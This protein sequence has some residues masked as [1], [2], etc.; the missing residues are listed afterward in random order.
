MDKKI[1]LSGAEISV[2]V[3]QSNSIS[4]SDDE[5][6]IFFDECCAEKICKMI[7][8]AAKELREEEKTE[9]TYGD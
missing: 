7:L 3:N 1:I 2:Y 5:S 4:I 8:E 6:C 9:I